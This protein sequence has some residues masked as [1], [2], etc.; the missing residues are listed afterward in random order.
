MIRHLVLFTLTDKARE[1]GLETVVE[2]LRRSAVSMAGKIPGLLMVEL[3]LNRAKSSP[4]DLIFYSE[5]EDTAA[6]E[7]YQHHPIH[8]EHKRFAQDYVSNPETVDPF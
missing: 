2:K 4:H 5:F 6:L 1:E 7:G 3:I 8:E